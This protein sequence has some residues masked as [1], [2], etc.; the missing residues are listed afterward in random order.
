MIVLRVV[1]LS[2][3]RKEVVYGRIVQFQAPHLV[4]GFTEKFVRGG[5]G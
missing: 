3:G 1:R 4:L 2:G 5:N